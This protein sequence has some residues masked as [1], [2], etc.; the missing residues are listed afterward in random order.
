MNRNIISE[1]QFCGKI[2]CKKHVHVAVRKTQTPDTAKT[3]LSPTITKILREWSQGFNC[4]TKKNGCI[5]ALAQANICFT[6]NAL[7]F[8]ISI[9]KIGFY[10]YGVKLLR[11]C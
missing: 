4:D 9:C 3:S 2:M 11:S 7:Q 10:N 1:K 6:F 5:N 8:L